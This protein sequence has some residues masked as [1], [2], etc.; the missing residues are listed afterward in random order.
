MIN[1]LFFVNL[2]WS[3]KWNTKRFFSNRIVR[4]FMSYEYLLECTTYECHNILHHNHFR[5]DIQVPVRNIHVCNQA[6]EYMNHNSFP[7]SQL[8]KHNSWGICKRHGHN[9][10]SCGHKWVQHRVSMD[11]FG[12]DLSV[13][14]TQFDRLFLRI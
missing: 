7:P 11:F 8:H 10:H 4:C 2:I 12:L 5:N 13:L 6:T 14:S 9:Q 3:Y 1:I